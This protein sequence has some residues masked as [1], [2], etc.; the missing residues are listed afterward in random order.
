[1]Q[2]IKKLFRTLKTAKRAMNFNFNQVGNSWNPQLLPPDAEIRDTHERLI[3]RCRNICDEDSYG[4]GIVTTFHENVVTS[5]GIQIQ[6]LSED[7]EFAKAVDAAW[8]KFSRDRASSLSADMNLIDLQK[9]AVT[10]YLSDGE[11]FVRKHITRDG[12][13][14]SLIDPPRIPYGLLTRAKTPNRYRNGIYVNDDTGRVLG[15]RIN[16]KAVDSYRLGVSVSE[17]NGTLVGADEI[18]HSAL[19]RRTDQI[20]GVPL[21]KP[22]SGRIYKISEYENAVL[23]NAIA[24]AKKYGFF[25]WDKDAEAPPDLELSF[26]PSK[27]KSGSFHELPIGVN[28]E[29]WQSQFPDDELNSFTRA[30]LLATARA[31]GVSYPTLSGDISSVNYASIRAATLQERT[32]WNSFQMFLFLEL[33]LPI[34]EAFFTDLLGSGG[35]LV[36]GQAVGL[37]RFDEV[38][39]VAIASTQFSEIDPKNENLVETARIQNLLISPSEVIRQRGGDPE[40]VWSRIA[41]D[42][43]AM[44]KA[45]IPSAFVNDL[46]LRQPEAV[47]E[48]ENA[49]QLPGNA[50]VEN[51]G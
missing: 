19:R 25:R 34:Y 17:N 45:G 12:F 2:F 20:R 7:Q 18:I 5:D 35:L 28:V 46:Y 16:D 40:E 4:A 51:G 32:V 33:L 13:K 36:R 44:L 3:A 26:Q 30:I 29:T 31:I 15:Y 21:L 39:K 37:D 27:E 10:G 43:E 6:N 22:V 41:K 8:K 42:I 24:S 9:Q 11:V 1:M 14:Y 48:L 38:V 49:G 47:I 23:E 50:E